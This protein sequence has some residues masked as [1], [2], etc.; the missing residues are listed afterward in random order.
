MRPGQSKKHAL[1]TTVA[2]GFACVGAGH[3]VRCAGGQMDLSARE[4]TSDVATRKLRTGGV[5]GAIATDSY[6]CFGQLCNFICLASGN[7]NLHASLAD[8]Y[9]L[10]PP[11]AR[12]STLARWSIDA[13]QAESAIKIH[14]SSSGR[15][16]LPR[17]INQRIDR[18][19]GRAA[20]VARRDIRPVMTGAIVRAARGVG[21]RGV[22][23]AT[24]A[25]PATP[26]ASGFS[27]FNS[28]SGF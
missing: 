25:R 24:T 21:S 22:A 11:A 18:L 14:Q 28:T 23:T 16:R 27:N 10:W 6:Q 4:S 9:E 8:V 15:R 13:N 3:A 5:R 1:T 2:A 12:Q 26:V 17:E 20:S 7:V 19:P